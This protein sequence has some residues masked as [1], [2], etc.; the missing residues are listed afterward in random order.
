MDLKKFTAKD[1]RSC[2]ELKDTGLAMTGK[3]VVIVMKDRKT[4]TVKAKVVQDTKAEAL[5]EFVA[6]STERDAQVY[7]DESRSYIRVNRKH[8]TVNHLIQEYVKDLA[9]T[10]A[11]LN[12][13]GLWSSGRIKACITNSVGSI[14]TGMY[15]NLQVNIASSNWIYLTRC[16][17]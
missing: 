16:T 2:K 3:S 13:L 4:N 1:L 5:Q 14:L 6:D 8:D 7:I 11:G 9:H 17:A 12:P 10:N 15:S